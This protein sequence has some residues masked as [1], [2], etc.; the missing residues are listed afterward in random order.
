MYK[1]YDIY[2][3][4]C[5]AVQCIYYNEH[6][7]IRTYRY[8]PAVHQTLDRTQQAIHKGRLQST[9]PSVESSKTCNSSTSSSS[10][11]EQNSPYIVCTC[12][13]MHACSWL[14]VLLG[15]LEHDAGEVS[16]ESGISVLRRVSSQQLQSQMQEDSQQVLP[17]SG[18][19]E[20]GEGG[21]GREG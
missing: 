9:V 6:S 10:N 19:G 3:N 13:S 1:Q 11:G 12:M 16:S 4:L 14:Q 21:G 17:G 7:F 18:W 8:K 2:Y 20:R 5:T 15:Y